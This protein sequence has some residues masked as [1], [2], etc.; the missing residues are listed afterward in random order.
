MEQDC[1]F[2]HFLEG[3]IV[4]IK[5]KGYFMTHRDGVV[6]EA[7]CVQSLKQ[8]Y[9]ILLG[10]CYVIKNNNSLKDIRILFF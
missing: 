7:G 8:T 9:F 2:L 5:K 1:I 4:L 6:P 10:T 3:E